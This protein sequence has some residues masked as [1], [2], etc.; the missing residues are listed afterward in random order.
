MDYD[1]LTWAFTS[2][3]PWHWDLQSWTVFNHQFTASRWQDNEIRCS[4]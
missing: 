1:W 4:F 3:L 2:L